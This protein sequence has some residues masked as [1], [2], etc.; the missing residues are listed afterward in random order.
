MSTY[1]PTSGTTVTT[2][3]LV[4]PG[5]PVILSATQVDNRIIRTVIV[6]PVMDANGDNLSGLTKLTIASIVIVGGINPFS[7]KTMVE[8][9]AITGIQKVD[10]VLTMDDAGQQKTADILIQSLGSSQAIS[11]ACAD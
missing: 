10:I 5:M 9:L 2:F 7:G 6:M 8:I 1:G 11:A 3:D 4:A